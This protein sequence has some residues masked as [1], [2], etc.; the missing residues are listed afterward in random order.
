MAKGIKLK[1][2]ENVE[3]YFEVKEKILGYTFRL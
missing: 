1:F 3:R 2:S